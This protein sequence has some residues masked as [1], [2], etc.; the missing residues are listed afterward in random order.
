MTNLSR[1]ER[2][3]ALRVKVQKKLKERIDNRVAPNPPPRYDEIFF[4]GVEWLDSL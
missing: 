4:Q 3:E 2:I 1:E